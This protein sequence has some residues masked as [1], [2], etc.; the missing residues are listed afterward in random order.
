[1]RFN[2]TLEWAKDHPANYRDRN[3]GRMLHLGT[4]VALKKG[5][6]VGAG[7]RVRRTQY[8]GDWFPFVQGDEP[9]QDK[10]RTLQLW[11]LNRGWTIFGF[12]PKVTLSTERRKSNAETLE[13]KR[14][15]AELH[16]ER[17]F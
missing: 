13:F 16:F 2:G 15:R 5:F 7:I 17:Q 10:T 14:R 4:S 6:T 12:S 9:R 3:T 1:M 8:Q 11:M